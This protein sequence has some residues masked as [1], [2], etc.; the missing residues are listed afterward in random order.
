M[1]SINGA[2]T[3]LQ[4]GMSSLETIW[5]A[6]GYSTEARAMTGLIA[7]VDWTTSPSTVRS[8]TQ[9]AGAG[10]LFQG[11]TDVAAIALGEGTIAFL[12]VTGSADSIGQFDTARVYWSPFATTAA[13]LKVQ[14]GA[15]FTGQ[16][17]GLIDTMSTAGDYI[18]LP[19][20][21]GLSASP[22]I[23]GV[24]VTQMSTGKVWA[25][26]PRSNTFMTLAGI[27]GSEILAF[28]WGASSQDTGLQ[29]WIRLEMSDLSTLV[30]S[31]PGTP[32]GDA[33]VGG[34]SSQSSSTSGTGGSGGH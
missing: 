18:A 33:G 20:Q 25:L 6:T 19:R 8:W 14:A 17:D 12:G 7:W 1:L 3:I 29:R 11:T 4:P 9:P 23:L 15:D 30:T 24:V 31:L 22:T 16:V 32:P 26:P 21:A 2:V 28:E 5:Q 34:S 10:S 13:G 27:S